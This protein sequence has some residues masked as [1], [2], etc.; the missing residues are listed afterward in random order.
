MYTYLVKSSIFNPHEHHFADTQA[1][2]NLNHSWAA[3]SPPSRVFV[4]QVWN[5]RLENINLS[6][7]SQEKSSFSSKDRDTEYPNPNGGRPWAPPAGCLDVTHA[8]TGHKLGS[9]YSDGVW[10]QYC[11]LMV[12][13]EQRFGYTYVAASETSS[14]SQFAIELA[15]KISGS[16]CSGQSWANYMYIRMSTENIRQAFIYSTANNTVRNTAG[17]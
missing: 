9:G 4:V 17:I 7:W 5:A 8:R 6:S 12:L 15:R 10:L 11:D 16:S 13:T 2:I 1:L 14:L 3:L